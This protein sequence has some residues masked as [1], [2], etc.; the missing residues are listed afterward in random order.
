MGRKA[1][2]IDGIDQY[3]F[4]KLARTEGTPRERRRFLVFAHIQEGISFSDAARMV[5]MAP[6]TVIGLVSKFR[7]SGIDGLREKPGRGA[8]PYVPK[9]DYEDFRKSV[10][11]LQQARS[12]G[13]IRGQDIG[14]LIEEK[15]GKRPSTSVIYKTLRR[16]GLVWI[17][18]RS[19][20]PKADPQTQ[21]TFKK[22]LKIKSQKSSQKELV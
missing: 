17:T 8:K 11:E 4:A 12:G 2:P 1:K 6:R 9:E 14:D 20:H 16:A 5:K 7:E 22:T 13:R 3:D 21:E 15:Y 18:G 19:Q 10:K